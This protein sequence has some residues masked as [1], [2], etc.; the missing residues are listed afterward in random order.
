MV[1]RCGQLQGPRGLVSPAPL[2]LRARQE[3]PSLPALHPPPVVRARLVL[4]RTPGTGVGVGFEQ[5]LCPNG[6]EVWA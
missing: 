6:Q 4:T 1:S 3:L 5:S 2:G